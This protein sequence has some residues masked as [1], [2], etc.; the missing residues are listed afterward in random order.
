MLDKSFLDPRKALLS[1]VGTSYWSHTEERP[2]VCGYPTH[3]QQGFSSSLSF[4]LQDCTGAV[5]CVCARAPM[6][7]LVLG[8]SS[9]DCLAFSVIGVLKD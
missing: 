4:W 9:S 5:L 2:E 6:L 3:F 1:G 8:P 7:G